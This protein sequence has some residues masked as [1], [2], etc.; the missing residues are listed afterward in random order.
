M[1][2]AI[3]TILCFLIFVSPFIGSQAQ[4]GPRRTNVKPS[5]ARG[6]ISSEQAM[7]NEARKLA[8]QFWSKLIKC[9]NSYF[10]YSDDRLF[11]FRDDPHFSFSGQALKPKPLSRVDVLNG[12]DPLPIEWD[13]ATNV[14]FE[15]CRMNTSYYELP[16][17]YGYGRTFWNGWGNWTNQHC[18]F[19]TRIWREKGQWNISSLKH[20]NCDDLAGWGFTAKPRNKSISPV[21][22]MPHTR[23]DINPALAS[24]VVLE[25]RVTGN[26]REAVVNQTIEIIKKR[27]E[28]IGVPIY[29]VERENNST[30]QI[31][32]KLPPLREPERTKSLIIKEARLEIVHVV[33][34]PS[35]SPP[36][37]YSTKE[38]AIQSLGGTVPPNRRV[39]PYTENTEAMGQQSQNYPS[40]VIAE[41]PSLID[42]SEWNRCQV[43][44]HSAQGEHFYVSCSLKD[45]SIDRLNVWIDANMN[46]YIGVVFD[47]K[48]TSVPFIRSRISRGTTIRLDLP[49]MNSATDA[50]IALNSGTL[51]AQ[52]VFLTEGTLK[53]FRK[54]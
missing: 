30:N 5:A 2:K 1:T 54:N 9:G 25:I 14:N 41:F 16:A 35:P 29:K 19:G 8:A 21:P 43:D 7:N 23:S 49:T 4:F 38:E 3:A 22:E 39:L 20:I 51:P 27:L 42:G 17:A 34:P 44:S 24:Y 28:L 47:G 53:S 18:E 45:T 33:S 31:V 12:V 15:V 10:L 26:N 40:W 37:T 6:S 50:A 36:Q 48:V 52:G 46:Q 13:G 11:E 32:V